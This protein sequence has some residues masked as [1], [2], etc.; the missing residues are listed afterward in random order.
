M[1]LGLSFDGVQDVGERRKHFRERRIAFSSAIGRVV[2]ARSYVGT[3]CMLR[4]V[5]VSIEA[6]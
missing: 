1:A 6:V 2:P 5:P 3:P 4:C